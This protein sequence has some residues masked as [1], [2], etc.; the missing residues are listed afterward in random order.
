MQEERK[1]L[2]NL[3]RMNWLA[4][5]GIAVEPWQV[6]DYRSLSWQELFGG[7]SEFGYDFDKNSF[8]AY[9]EQVG[10][11][12]EFCDALLEEEDFDPMEQDQIYLLV[13]ELWR[14]LVP[15]KICISVFCDELDHQIFLFDKGDL[16]I[17]ES[18]QD[19]VANLQMIMDENY[20][21]GANPE[22]V[23]RLVSKSCANDLET[24]LY[25]YIAD[26]LESG[27]IAYAS[28]L[29]DGF[30]DYLKGSKWMQ[31]ANIRLQEHLDQEA[32]DEELKKF[33]ARMVKEDD[34][35]FNLELLSFIAQAGDKSEFSKMVKR[36]VALLETEED[37]LDLLALCEEFYR[38]RDDDQKEKEVQHILDKREKL[39]AGSPIKQGDKDLKELLKILR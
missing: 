3:L 15:E 18:I 34:L 29:N 14:R 30:I 38:F 2:Y 27:N 7:L 16:S 1:T 23:F 37:F 39:D 32:A 19:A 8:L 13:F 33:V 5:P 9:A 24:F 12:E 31:L 20:D 6:E 11:P 26:Q 35:R 10:S 28:D 25:D 21:Q 22:E 4:D 17:A 36:T